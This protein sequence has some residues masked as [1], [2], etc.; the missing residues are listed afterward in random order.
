MI[1]V[2]VGGFFVGRSTTTAASSPREMELT[3][4]G[5]P[6]FLSALR[7]GDKAECLDWVKGNFTDPQAGLF[8]MICAGAP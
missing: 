4:H 1:L 5:D 8:A 6:N 7:A 3:I 2:F